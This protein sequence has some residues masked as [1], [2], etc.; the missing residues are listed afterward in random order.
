M[1]GPGL[2]CH[3]ALVALSRPLAF[4]SGCTECR[5]P[6]FRKSAATPV[7]YLEHRGVQV[8][9]P[10]SPG[11]HSAGSLSPW[12]AVLCGCGSP[13]CR[14]PLSTTCWGCGLCLT[15]P[16]YSGTDVWCQHLCL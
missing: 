13:G 12:W 2:S 7:R 4:L 9:G 16:A 1:A 5:R 3:Q 10:S 6:G 15:G 14:R 11:Q 8:C